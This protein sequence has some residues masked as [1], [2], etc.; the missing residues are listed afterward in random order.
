MT[1]GFLQGSS[2]GSAV[3]SVRE[4][5][6]KLNARSVILPPWV[7]GV[8]RMNECLMSS[9]WTESGSP[10]SP[11]YLRWVG[12]VSQPDFEPHSPFP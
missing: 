10:F 2:F 1:C 3:I 9:F 7:F 5:L 4:C 12:R 6:C 8:S 11:C